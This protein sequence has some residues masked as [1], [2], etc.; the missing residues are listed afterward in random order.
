MFHYAAIRLHPMFSILIFLQIIGIN[1]SH[2]SDR[3]IDLAFKNLTFK[4]CLFSIREEI[5]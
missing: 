4:G 3:S 1:L 2:G 5:C